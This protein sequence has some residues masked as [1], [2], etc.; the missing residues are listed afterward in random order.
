MKFTFFF[1]TKKWRWNYFC[2]QKVK[3]VC[4]KMF[5]FEENI[6]RIICTSNGLIVISILETKKENG[7]KKKTVYIRL[8]LKKKYCRHNLVLKKG[9]ILIHRSGG[10]SIIV[11]TVLRAMVIRPRISVAVSILLL[12]RVNCKS[13]ENNC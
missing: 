1:L 10:W 4:V 9:P 3:I 7:F 5:R 6:I 11:R 2:F 13:F 12:L 8:S